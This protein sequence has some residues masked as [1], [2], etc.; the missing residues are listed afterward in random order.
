[1]A[2]KGRAAVA[3]PFEGGGWQ[4]PEIG[5]KPIRAVPFTLAGGPGRCPC[6]HR[7]FHAR[8]RQRKPVLKTG[9]KPA[10]KPNAATA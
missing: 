6:A 10:R 3:K 9:S 8:K 5:P 4:A 1:M 7:T 2:F